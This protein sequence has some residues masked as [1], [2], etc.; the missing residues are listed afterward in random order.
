MDTITAIRILNDGVFISIG[1]DNI[2]CCAV[3]VV[4]FGMTCVAVVD[5]VDGMVTVGIG[6]F[7]ITPE[8][9]LPPDPDIVPVCVV[10]VLFTPSVISIV[11]PAVCVLLT[12][13][14]V[15]VADALITIKKIRVNNTMYFVFMILSPVYIYGNVIPPIVYGIVQRPITCSVQGSDVVYLSSSYR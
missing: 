2:D 5:S 8:L 11:P 10:C 12:P 13:S 1:I 14:V 4:C 3:I 6:V 15:Y 9:P 7:D